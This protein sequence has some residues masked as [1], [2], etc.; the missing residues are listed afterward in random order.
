MPDLWP[1]SAAECICECL[2]AISYHWHLWEARTLSRRSFTR[3]KIRWQEGRYRNAII[4]NPAEDSR[5]CKL[6]TAEIWSVLPKN[7]CNVTAT[8]LPNKCNVTAA[9]FTRS[10][11]F[12]EFTWDL[13]NECLDSS[14]SR[15]IARIWNQICMWLWH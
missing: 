14:T 9:F 12:K 10:P 13:Q 5:V 2:H 7:N 8:L 1:I 6:L 4:N 3:C 15:F 11:K